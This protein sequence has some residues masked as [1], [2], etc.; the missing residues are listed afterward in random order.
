MALGTQKI[1]LGAD[2]WL[3]PR[4]DRWNGER[5]S[6]KLGRAF[7]EEHDSL[8]R[9][10]PVPCESEHSRSLVNLCLESHAHMMR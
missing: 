1:F 4:I 7:A 9:F 8:A 5:E 10:L 2:C 6:G 3:Q